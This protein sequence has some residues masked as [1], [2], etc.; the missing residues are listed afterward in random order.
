MKESRLVQLLSLC[1]RGVVIFRAHRTVRLTVWRCARTIL[2]AGII[3]SLAFAQAPAPSVFAAGPFTVNTANDT[4]CTGFSSQGAPG[5]TAATDGSG[6]ISLRSALEYASTAGG[7][8]TI[9]LPSGTYNLS[10]GDLVAGTQANTNITIPGTST[11][12]NT[13]IHQSQHKHNRQ[14]AYCRRE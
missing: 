2:I 10:L 6:N 13:T 12:A 4:H 8:T 7:T 14:G 3:A 11:S 5:C 9:N 1:L